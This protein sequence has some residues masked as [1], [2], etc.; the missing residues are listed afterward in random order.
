M[1]DVRY[2]DG[3][4]WLSL[5]GPAGVP[6]S[7]AGA[8]FGDLFQTDPKPWTANAQF[9]D[10]DVVTYQG[11]I[12]FANGAIPVGSVPGIFL[13]WELID[14]DVLHNNIKKLGFY[15][16]PYT[17]SRTRTITAALSDRVSVKDFGAVG[18]GVTDDTA[19]I[20][21]ALNTGLTTYLP[22]GIY[23]VS[24]PLIMAPYVSGLTGAPALR[25][26]SRALTIIKFTE[27]LN[28]ATHEGCII[29][30]S[31]GEVT[32]V[33]LFAPH[34]GLYN[35]AG[36]GP[37]PLVDSFLDDPALARAALHPYPP[38]ISVQ[39]WYCVIRRIKM[40]HGID[41]IE[42][43]K[44][45]G[46]SAPSRIVIDDVF[47]GCPGTNIR[48]LGCNGFARIS[49]LSGEPAGI[50]GYDD[51][52]MNT[53]MWRD[54]KG[55]ALVLGSG[56]YI[57][58][59]LQGYSQKWAFGFVEPKVLTKYPTLDAPDYVYKGLISD[60]GFFGSCNSGIATATGSISGTTLTITTISAAVIYPE[61][62]VYGTGVIKGTRI[63]RQLTGTTGNVGTYEVTISQ[64][65]AS[66]A[67]LK[68][69]IGNAGY[70][71]I[72]NLQLDSDGAEMLIGCGG[73][74]L[75]NFYKSGSNSKITSFAAVP[76]YGVSAAFT[77]YGGSLVLSNGSAST[78]GFTVA[79]YVKDVAQLPV[80]GT[81]GQLYLVGYTVYTWN[82]VGGTEAWRVIDDT[83]PIFDVRNHPR[84]A[85]NITLNHCI[86]GLGANVPLA[87]VRKGYFSLS[88]STIIP[89]PTRTDYTD[90]PLI[91]QSLDASI[92]LVDNMVP[93]SGPNRGVLCSFTSDKRHIFTNNNAP[94]WKLATT[95]P[96]PISTFTDNVL[97]EEYFD[98]TVVNQRVKVISG[99]VPAAAAG[100]LI[101]IGH[102]LNTAVPQG[103]ISVAFYEQIGT[104]SEWYAPKI[105][106]R[107]DTGTL[108]FRDTTGN[109]VFD[110]DNILTPGQ[111]YTCRIVYVVGAPLIAALAP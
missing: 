9:V 7:S 30:T 12:Y 20:Q 73:V 85:P 76:Y 54:N 89:T 47:L 38:L 72:T 66:T 57:L 82:N 79:G 93:V 87:K 88:N 51:P 99:K 83:W 58:E 68:F 1:S 62:Q 100:G 77:S 44:P 42:A 61:C 106:W 78:I 18:D 70:Y 23:I 110:A 69:S 84:F 101:S 48:M 16:A 2:F 102:G 91:E 74:T 21:M 108:I 41:G 64:T 104:T 107:I 26:E 40:G 43:V 50:G 5:Q 94:S 80:T 105:P 81:L 46:H 86:F 96:L 109:P 22:K 32:D 37:G 25:G 71:F 49:N 10:R 56:Y 31:G 103:I 92:R 55:F 59:N 11:N 15:T 98:G 14:I 34:R 67:A 75:S 27:G 95:I 28:S 36:T 29:I 19:A 52:I 35:A 111:R 3:T 24:A 17:Q 97:A 90:L 33:T 4:N 65:L 8:N 39:G 53:G 60:Q 45:Y 13:G 63:V 6:G